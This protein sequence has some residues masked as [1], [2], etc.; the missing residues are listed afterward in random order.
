VPGKDAPTKRPR[1]RPRT[2]KARVILK[3]DPTLNKE[4]S[5]AALTKGI[6]RSGFVEKAVRQE[7]EKI[8]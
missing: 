5:A 8:S 7:M 1:G 6:T 4:L 3:L 2:H